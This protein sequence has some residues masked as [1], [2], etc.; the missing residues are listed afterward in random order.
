MPGWDF[1]HVQND[2]NVRILRKLK[3]NFSLGVPY[4]LVLFFRLFDLRN[5]PYTTG[6]I[7]SWSKELEHVASSELKSFIQ[8]QDGELFQDLF[9]NIISR[10]FKKICRQPQFWMSL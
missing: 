4:H 10:Q 5:M 3:G 6:R 8:V 1:A 7:L 2:L 9:N